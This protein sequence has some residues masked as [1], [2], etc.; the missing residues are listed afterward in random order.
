VKLLKRIILFLLIAV[1]LLLA[2]AITFTMGW[3]PFIGPRVRPATNLKVETTA[4]RLER[5]SYLVNG[6]MGCMYC[7]SEHDA[8][9]PGTPPKTAGQGAGRLMASDADLGTFYSANITPDHETGIGDWTDGE[10]ARAI[11][12]GISRDGRALFPAMPYDRFRRMPDEDL[13][14]VIVYLRSLPAVRNSVP[15][16]AI[17]FPI[18]RL[19]LSVP[20]P[21][22]EPVRDPEF[23]SIRERGEHLAD[24][25][26]CSG[27]HTPFDAIGTPMASLAFAGGNTMKD[28]DDKPITSLNLTPDASGIPYYDEAT[29]IKTIR[30]GQIGAR[31]INS[32][33]PWTVYRNLND[34]DLKA[35]YAFIHTLK[36][37]VHKVDNTVEPTMCPV[38]GREHGLGEMNK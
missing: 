2:V 28:F 17:H 34:D 37:V 21:V 20:E 35:I 36:P 1:P 31:K 12:E 25:A 15:K 11:R 5:G 23:H 24:M 32:V 26:S 33:M 8:S 22:D 3:R 29:F 10:I 9:L 30:T 13:G 19:V 4:A 14:A 7:H 38:C 16:P 27:C 18:N 6:L